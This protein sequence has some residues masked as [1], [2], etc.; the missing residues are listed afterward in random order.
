VTSLNAF[1][2]KTAFSRAD[3][4]KSL[5]PIPYRNLE[6]QF[7]H[8]KNLALRYADDTR[9][10]GNRRILELWIAAYQRELDRRVRLYRLRSDDP[11]LPDLGE[12]ARDTEARVA[13]VKDAWPILSFCEEV[14]AARVHCNAGD[15]SVACCPLPGHDDTTPS[16]VI[17]EATDSAWCFGCGRGGDILELIGIFFG[18]ERFFDR[19]EWR[20]KPVGLAT[21]RQPDSLRGGG[22]HD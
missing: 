5:E 18:L 13:V 14:L 15:R 11:L 12:K 10:G 9:A 2:T 21:S 8:L 16:F 17:Y 7:E 22:S 1:Y 3:Y 20:E 6:A 19:L 4:Q